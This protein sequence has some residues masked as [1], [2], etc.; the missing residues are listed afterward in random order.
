MKEAGTVMRFSF[1]A[2]MLAA[3]LAFGA[4]TG[5]AHDHGH[6]AEP[7]VH[8]PW[9]RPTPPGSK[10]TAMY[11]TIVN[12]GEKAIRLVGVSSGVAEAVEI[13][14]VVKQGGMMHMRPVSGGITVP[15]RGEFHFQP[16]GYHLMLIGLKAPIKAGDD[17]RL[18]FRFA[19]GSEVAVSA[20]AAEVGETHHSTHERHAE[21]HNHKTP[22][23]EPQ[24]GEHK[25][26]TPHHEGARR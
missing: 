22:Q 9:V 8:H 18:A 14:Q 13:H 5:A 1:F 6:G 20:R 7:Q 21:G 24:A 12:P 2:V 11:G 25:H 15:A 3:G 17:V 4:S 23:H 16:G 26:M 10:I 19:D